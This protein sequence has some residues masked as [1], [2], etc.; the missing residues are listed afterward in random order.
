MN[1]MVL[2]LVRLLLIDL[3]FVLVLTG[4]IAVLAYSR[5]AA[6]AVLRR[7]FVGYFSN[8]TGYVFLCIFVLLS[9]VAAFWPYDFFNSNLA[10]L[11]QLSRFMP[12]I[13]LVFIPAITMSIWADERRQGTDELLLTLPADD[14]DI[15]IGKFL[16]AA[17]IFTGSLLFSQLATFL[18][19]AILS[20]GELDVGLFATTFFGYWLMGITMIAVG[21]VASF[22]SANLTVAFLLGALFNAPLAFASL[23]DVILPDSGW[24]EIV[25]S[26]GLAR[27][28][29][30]LGR[31]VISLASIAYFLLVTSLGLY[32][33]MVLIGR[34]HWTG[35]KDGNTMAWHY[36]ARLLALIVLASGL[37]VLLRTRDPL[38]QDMTEGQVSSLSPTTK[39]LIRDLN[40]ERPIVIDAYISDNIPEQ[41]SR[42]RYELINLLKEFS[43]EAARKGKVIDVRLH[44]GIEL[45]SD[46]AKEAEDRFGIQPATRPVRERGTYRNE[47]VLFGAAIRSGLNKVIIPFFEYGIPVE[48]ELVRSI[49]TVAQPQRKKLGVVRTD[50]QLMGGFTFAGMSP[51]QIPK[52]PLITELEKQYE[53]QEVDLS[54]P[55]APGQFDVLLAVQPSSLSPEQMSH[56]VESVRGGVPTAIF[57]D[58]FPFG[59]SAP[60]TGEPKQ[61]PGGMF[62]GGAPQPKGDIRQLWDL[63]ELDIPGRPAMTGG[64]NPDLVWQ[65]YNPYPKLRAMGTN[66]LWLF[67]REET[68][69]EHEKLSEE[70]LV[71]S[72]LSEV[73]MLYSGAVLP[74]QQA[75]LKHTPL[76]QTGVM[77]GLIS[78]DDV[79]ANSRDPNALQRAQGKPIGPQ[80]VAMAIEGEP[81]PALAATAEGQP[82]GEAGGK[83]QA[84]YIADSDLMMPVF[85]QIRSQPNQFE[86]I[87]FRFENITFL[88]NVIDSLAGELDYIEVRKHQ[89]IFPTLKLIE[90]V[91]AVAREEEDLEREKFNRDYDEAIRTFDEDRTKEVRKVQEALEELQKKG[92]K[93]SQDFALLQQKQTELLLKEKQLDRQREV[94]SAKLARDRDREIN[95]IR[96]ATERKVTRYQNV[97]KFAAATLPCI[98]PLLIGLIVFA[99][100]RLKE[101]ETITKARLK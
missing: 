13:L 16:S 9:C 10:T 11:D 12:L 34:R 76:L 48:Y 89:P 86:E 1:G 45:F 23:A 29:D 62:G 41:Y 88:L 28:F 47:E 44:D 77:A 56:F 57:E 2:A 94:R 100:R 27:H 72:G 17:A 70:S 14:F 8:P 63:L 61:S 21:M 54:G 84:I 71:T 35:G 99:N 85:M 20:R 53:V 66:D 6:Y 93:N 52:N 25:R 79:Q 101:R 24:A 75:K 80:T 60:G 78:N 98:P 81:A 69:G 49:N 38:R 7:N 73:L 59:M 30:D 97:V 87:D 50:A 4:L 39:Q 3:A 91:E 46:Q 33:C 95:R 5:P 83:I 40:P 55:V 19:L 22:L 18:T 51:Q 42:T 58:P 31:G 36:L 92:G 32:C 65:A 26:A 74:K 15:V 43:S 67:L 64:I 90:E 37:M 82:A 96:T 68:A